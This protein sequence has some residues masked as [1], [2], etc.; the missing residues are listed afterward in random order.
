MEKQS[1]EKFCNT[2]GV[3]SQFRLIL[4]ALRLHEEVRRSDLDNETFA[5][6]YIT[7]LFCKEVHPPHLSP[8]FLKGD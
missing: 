4:S 6:N 7:T 3:L 2:R 8:P 5:E 1:S